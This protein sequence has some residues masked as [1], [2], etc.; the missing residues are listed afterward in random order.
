M[1]RTRHPKRSIFVLI[2]MMEVELL[3]MN[4]ST[5]TWPLDFSHPSLRRFKKMH[6]HLVLAQSKT[7]YWTQ[8]ENRI[9]HH[10]PPGTQNEH[11]NNPDTSRTSS[12]SSADFG[13]TKPTHFPTLIS[14]LANTD[15]LSAFCSRLQTT[16]AL[17]CECI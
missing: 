9:F 6:E 4:F 10:A 7:A 16:P 14:R 11:A 1:F 8:C 3:L 15:T 17:R 12:G 5:H 2:M 13:A